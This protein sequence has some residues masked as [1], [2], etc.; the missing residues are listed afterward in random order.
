MKKVKE[1]LSKECNRYV[2][3]QCTTYS[4]IRRA[5]WVRGPYDPNIATCE[6]H[7]AIKEIEQLEK[8][9]DELHDNIQGMGN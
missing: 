6:Y 5:G 2:N 9:V 4:C 8:Y 1:L 3:G 7:E